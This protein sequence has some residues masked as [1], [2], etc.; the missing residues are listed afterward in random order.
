MRYLEDLTLY[1]CMKGGNKIIDATSVQNDI[2]HYMPQLQSF[3]FYI[4]TYAD[5]RD[6]SSGLPRQDISIGYPNTF[7]FVN[8]VSPYAVVCSIFSLPF[9]FDYLADLGN[10]FPDVV[11]TKVTYL[12][13]RD[14]DV[15]KHEFFVRIAR[16]FPL[17]KH[18]CILNIESQLSADLL[19]SSSDHLQSYSMIEYSYLESLD[20]SDSHK[21]YLEQFLNETKTYVPCLTEL[22][23]CGR[24]LKTVTENFSREVTR[25]NCATIKRLIID[26]PLDNVEGYSHYFPSL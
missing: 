10:V 3:T 20:V 25:R 17:L 11:F 15:F 4:S 8:H 26:P 22:K 16:S 18:L 7:S 2:L 12:F 1:L 24:A 5:T 9:E 13:V 23:V 14:I 19:A 6:L 21:D